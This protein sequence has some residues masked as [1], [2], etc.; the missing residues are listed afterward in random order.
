MRG[1]VVCRVIDS[2]SKNFQKGDLT[3]SFIGWREY[4]VVSEKEL[5][6]TEVPSGGQV[7][8][9]LGILG[10]WRRVLHI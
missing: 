9:A 5:E 7:T 3:T 1:G 10:M 4:A 8:D 2:K 6:K